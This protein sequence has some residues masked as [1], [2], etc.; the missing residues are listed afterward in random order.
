M[1]LSAKFIRMC[2]LKNTL[3]FSLLLLYACKS[4]NTD[5]SILIY[6][7]AG[8]KPVL[9][10]VAKAYEQDCH[11]KVDIQYGGSGTLLSNLRIAQKGDLYLAA[12]KSYLQ[13]AKGYGLIAETQPLAYLTPVVATKKGNTHIVQQ[14]SDL[15]TNKKWSLCIANPDAAAVGKLTKKIFTNLKKW[16]SLQTHIKVLMPTVSE[17]ANTLKLGTAD[18]GVIWD[19]TAAQYKDVEIAGDFFK[20]Y[21]KSVT[22]GVL[23]YTQQPTA[24]LKFLRYLSAQDKG[25]AVFREL[26]YNAIVGDAWVEKPTVLFYSGGVNRVAVDNIIN[27]FERR[28][29]VQVTRVYNGCGILVAQIKSGAIPDAY[30]SCDASFM[31]DVATDF[32]G[33]T[34][35]S[36]TPI[37]IATQKGNPKGIQSLKDLSAQGLKIGICNE[38]QSALGALTKSMLVKKGLWESIKKNIRSQTP[39]ADL[40]VNQL[41]TGSLD[42]VIVYQANVAQVTAHLDILFLADKNAMAF[43]NFGTHKQSKNS[44]LVRRMFDFITTEKAKKNYLNNG[45]RWDFKGGN[46]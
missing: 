43:Q 38:R 37:V 20:K 40:L 15:W 24:A 46:Q 44:F 27:D 36:K 39:T 26:G 7:A 25:L 10:K 28:E 9:D 33:I 41:R 11:V 16:D 14:L 45:F 29:G 3:L 18:V 2:F 42:A 12:D 19:A 5:K 4:S 22:I 21:R 23:N 30:L 17:V 34:D 32:K 35:V 13:K 31:T 8:M 1:M 6:C